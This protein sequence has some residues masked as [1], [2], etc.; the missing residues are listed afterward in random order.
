MKIKKLLAI[1]TVIIMLMGTAS[2][3]A[4]AQITID[5][6]QFEIHPGD[7]QSDSPVYSMAWLDD[8]VIRSNT[9]DFT[10][11]K[12]VPKPDY[13]Y[14]HTYDGFIREV[15]NYSKINDINDKTVTQAYGA[16]LD[17]LYYTFTAIG[18]TDD[19]QSM[20]VYLQEYGIDLPINEESGD[21]IATAVVFAALRYNALYVL[22]GKDVDIPQGSSLGKASAIIL[23]KLLNVE[24][25]SSVESITGF[26]M[27]CL[28]QYVTQFE[29]IPLSDNPSAAEIFHWVKIIVAAS[30]DYEVPLG[31][32]DQISQAQRDYVDYAYYASLF[33]GAYD[34]HINPIYMAMADQRGDSEALPKLILTTMLDTSKVP[35]DE[36]ASGETLFDLACKAGYFKLDDEFFADV[37]N[38]DVTVDYTDEKLWVTPFALA[39]Q[40]GGDNK[41]V[42]MNLNG[43]KM[44]HAQTAFAPLDPSKDNETV[45]LEVEYDDGKEPA[46]TVTYTF[47]VKKAD[48]SV[49]EPGNNEVLDKVEEAVDKVIPQDNQEVSDLV[50]NLFDSI[51]TII[52]TV[53]TLP[54]EGSQQEVNPAVDDVLSTYPEAD[55]SQS[56]NGHGYLNSLISDTYPTDENGDI[57]T[58]LIIDAPEADSE[59]NIAQK[60]ITAIKENPEAAV[61]A[62]SSV[63][64]LGSFVG[65]MLNKK[66]KNPSSP[67]DDE[68]AQDD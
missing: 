46:E 61:A 37:F 25:P 27:T 47:N 28:K 8:I 44:L 64:A 42:T 21:K 3:S 52:P 54:D 48:L 60:A 38:Y 45:T 2:Q 34:I 15:N 68:N 29:Q 53:P 18:M 10:P 19:D 14:S 35:Y 30:N 58:D 43:K 9:T 41:Y 51:E 39:Y 1:V 55:T 33:D 49:V 26:G 16:I 5:S 32:Y 4:F 59:P 24:L 57:V 7:T 11:S 56:D 67:L 65:Y 12:I 50:E 22:Y 66:R 36:D 63:I 31:Q 40:L 17:A 6:S 13:P 23:S 62:P 20:R